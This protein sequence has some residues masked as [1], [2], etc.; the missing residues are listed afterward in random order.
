MEVWIELI[1]F[2]SLGMYEPQMISCGPSTGGGGMGMGRGDNGEEELL[3]NV[4]QTE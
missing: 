1:H 2:L 4:V 3:K